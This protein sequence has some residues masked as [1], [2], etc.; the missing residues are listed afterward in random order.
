MI[1]FVYLVPSRSQS[2]VNFS[3]KICHRKRI[4]EDRSA[5]DHVEHKE[6]WKKGS[7]LGYLLL[8][9]YFSVFIVMMFRF[10]KIAEF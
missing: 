4:E 8:I 9:C 7:Y 2:T 1:F 10:C 5:A 6:P 3:T